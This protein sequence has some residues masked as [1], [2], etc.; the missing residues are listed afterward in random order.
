MAR[1]LK[2]GL[3]IT[4]LVISLIAGGIAADRAYV[5]PQIDELRNADAILV[6][7]GDGWNRY[8]YAMRLAWK[9]W[10][11]NLVISNPGEG[12]AGNAWLNKTCSEPPKEFSI[13]CIYPKP[14]TTRGEA[15]AFSRLAAEHNW[16]SVIVVTGRPHISR[17]RLVIERCFRGDIIM[18]PGPDPIPRSQW[19]YEFVYQTLGFIR[20]M[21]ERKCDIQQ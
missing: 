16:N 13:Y 14:G 15:M 5:H 2:R 19:A 4:A 10:A 9:A 11:P 18:I 7:G 21:F 6:I 17:A 8:S 12:A 1:W 20:S 3:T